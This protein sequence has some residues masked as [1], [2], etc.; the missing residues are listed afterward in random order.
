M[1]SVSMLDK[2]TQTSF[3]RLGR[4][5]DPPSGSLELWGAGYAAIHR[6]DSGCLRPGSDV[7]PGDGLNQTISKIP[8]WFKKKICIQDESCVLG[9]QSVI[10]TVQD[11]SLRTIQK[12]ATT[13]QG[14]V[15]MRTWV[16]V[17]EAE[18]ESSIE[19]PEA[20]REEHSTELISTIH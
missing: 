16:Y 15:Q 17:F 18:R 12:D 19:V 4:A 9:R 14:H 7:F 20:L 6:G 13:L 10:S 3:G 5:L 11:W 1:E 2:E 8:T